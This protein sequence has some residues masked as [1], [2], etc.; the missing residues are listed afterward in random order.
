LPLL[1]L[2]FL[3]R[4]MMPD[5]ATGRRTNDPMM[6]S[7]VPC[8]ATYN[9]TLDATFC[10]GTVRADQEHKTQQGCGKHLHLHCHIPRHTIPPSLCTT[11]RTPLRT[12]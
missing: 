12:P 1:L 7:H 2:L 3:F 5:S 8:Y 6:A 11:I 10:V 4:E 9:G